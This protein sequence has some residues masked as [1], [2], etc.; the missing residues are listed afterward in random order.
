MSRQLAPSGGGGARAG[1]RL[2]VT[3]TSPRAGTA[4]GPQALRRRGLRRLLLQ[5]TQQRVG[6]CPRAPGPAGFAVSDVG[7]VKL[8]VGFGDLGSLPPGG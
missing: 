7:R 4:A 5:K 8:G 3:A 1:H 2:T 6:T